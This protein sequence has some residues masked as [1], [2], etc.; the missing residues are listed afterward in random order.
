MLTKQTTQNS[1]SSLV[2]STFQRALNASGNA[3]SDGLKEFEAGTQEGTEKF[4]KVKTAI[5]ERIQEGFERQGKAFEGVANW[6]KG[7]ATS[8]K[9]TFDTAG[10]EIAQEAGFGV[11]HIRRQAGYKAAFDSLQRELAINDS[12]VGGSPTISKVERQE[13]SG[14][15]RQDAAAITAHYTE[16][17][18]ALYIKNSDPTFQ[19]AEF[20]ELMAETIKDGIQE[21]A[22]LTATLKATKAAVVHAN[23]GKERVSVEE[24]YESVRNAPV[25]AGADTPEYIKTI[26]GLSSSSMQAASAQPPE[27]EQNT[28]TTKIQQQVGDATTELKTKISAIRATITNGK[29]AELEDL[30]TYI[31]EQNSDTDLFIPLTK[32]TT[33]Q[34][35]KSALRRS[36]RLDFL[37]Q[38]FDNLPTLQVIENY[39]A[40]KIAENKTIVKA[41]E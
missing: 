16:K 8:I 2:G 6:V 11:D 33:K 26:A 28:L 17:M 22:Q 4:N 20:R 30:A 25:R 21:V 18:Q 5:E 38:H 3:V 10:Q 32:G 41:N 19:R 36:D 37:A 9:N 39:A 40:K 34:Q 7:T 35:L 15:V 29:K 13:L 27:A 1:S 12:V 31:N 23:R 14:L 24:V